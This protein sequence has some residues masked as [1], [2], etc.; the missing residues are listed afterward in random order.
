MSDASEPPSSHSIENED[1]DIPDPLEQLI[2]TA[3][4]E[5]LRTALKGATSGEEYIKRYVTDALA[6]TR[7]ERATKESGA[8]GKRKA[9][10]V[11]AGCGEEFEEKENKKGSCSVY[12]YHPESPSLDRSSDYWE[13]MWE[14][15]FE[16]MD[17][18][19][20]DHPEGFSF[21]CCDQDGTAKGCERR[22]HV[23][24]GAGPNKASAPTGGS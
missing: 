8:S 18:G 6:S 1:P 3:S 4:T 2:D 19:F 13:D 20:E 10:E 14:G 11:C 17:T 15:D 21:Y 7:R 16:H 5:D 22:F 23:A 24:R 9:M 12:L